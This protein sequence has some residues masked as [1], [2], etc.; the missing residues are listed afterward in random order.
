MHVAVMPFAAVAIIV[1]LPK[2]LPVTNPV[3]LTAA[4]PELTET[5]DTA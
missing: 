5:H 4:M 2:P 1:T 3:L